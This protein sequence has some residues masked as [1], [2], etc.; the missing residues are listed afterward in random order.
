MKGMSTMRVIVFVKATD[1]TESGAMPDP[2]V[3]TRMLTEMG[4]YNEEL[5]NAGLMQD[6]D[7]LQPSSRGARVVFSGDERTV[8]NGPFPVNEVVAGYWVWKVASMDEAIEWAKRCPN[9]TGGSSVL[10]IRPV[11][12]AEDFG[13]A[14]TPE[15]REAEEA[16][17]ARVES[18][19]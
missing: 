13:D 17:R 3:M 8:E 19:A 2:E 11:M 6:G 5:V 16:L 12:V 4:Q 18:G 15:L 10:E 9:P 7:G 14:L 1:E